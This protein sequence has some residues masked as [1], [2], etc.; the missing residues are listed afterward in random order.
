MQSNA[1]A[2]TLKN[3]LTKM[4]DPEVKI[5]VLCV[6]P[7]GAGKT[8]LLKKLQNAECIDNTYS[9]VPTLGT[10]IYKYNYQ[11]KAGK[12]KILVVREIGGEMASL[13]CNFLDGIEKVESCHK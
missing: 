4:E 12:K 3:Y 13:W 9:P 1:T 11:N 2:I 10:N 8:T 5:T 6:G 7:K